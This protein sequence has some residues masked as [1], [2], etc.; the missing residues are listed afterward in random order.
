MT[1]YAIPSQ[2]PDEIS[3]Q[4]AQ[5]SPRVDDGKAEPRWPAEALGTRS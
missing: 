5:V 2:D 4:L 1:D 3:R